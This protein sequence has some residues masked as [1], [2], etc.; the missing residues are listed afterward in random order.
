MKKDITPPPF[1]NRL[2]RWFCSPDLY[3][4]LAGDLAE[5]FFQEEATLDYK[6]AC[7]NYR[8]EV[9][10]M[11]RPSVIKRFT[12]SSLLPDKLMLS[13]YLKI[14]SRSLQ[15]QIGYTLTNIS[16][17]A[18]G[19]TACLLILLY[20]WGES[21]FDKGHEKG[22]RIFRLNT[23]LKLPEQA[24]ALSLTGGPVGP[25]LAH[26]F[27]EIEGVVRLAR[28]WSTLHLKK[29]DKQFYEENVLYADSSFFQLFDFPFIEGNQ[30]SALSLPYSVVISED[31][32]KKYF[33]EGPA[34]GKQL[35]INNQSFTVT[36]I[37]KDLPNHTHVKAD[38]YLSFSS[39][40]IEYPSTATSW[41]WTSF[42]T[43]LLLKPGVDPTTFGQ[44]IAYY[45]KDHV[46]EAAWNQTAMV[47]HLEP[48]EN[49]YFNSPRLG[50]WHAKGSKGYLLF[51]G[52]AAF[53]ILLMAILN[54]INL[55][56]ARAAIRSK[57]IGIRK[58]IGAQRKQLIQQFLTESG[59]LVFIAYALSF[60]ILTLA[61]PRFNQLIDRQLSIV[62]ILSFKP[63]ALVLV[64][65]LTISL[66]AGFYPAFFLSSFKTNS[67]LLKKVD[68]S[69]KKQSFWQ[70]LSGFQF[71]TS[72][73][74]IICTVIA[75]QQVQFMLH[76]DPGFEPDR[77]VVMAFGNDTT[78]LSHRQY[79][80][81]ELLRIPGI[82]AAAYSSHVPSESPHGVYL[83]VEAG[84]GDAREGETE[85][86]AVDQYFIDLYQLKLIAGKPFSTEVFTDSTA[87]LIVNASTVK[88]LGFSTPEEIIGKEFYQWDRRGRVI[89][90]V[91]DFNFKSLHNKIGA[92]T[93][94]LR[95]PLF[96]K[97]TIQYAPNRSTADIIEQLS[98]KWQSLAGHLPFQYSFLDQRIAQLYQTDKRFATLSLLFS[99]LA[100]FIALLGL[101]ALVGY[102]C[103]RQAKDIAV[104]KVFGATAFQ[105]I[106]SLFR[107][108]SRP[109][110]WA[111]L[112][113][114]VPVYFLLDQ[115]LNDFTYRIDISWLVLIGVGILGFLCSFL[116]VFGQSFATAN[117][118]PT[119]YLR[120]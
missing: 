104:K 40:I 35:N 53:F 83:S 73:S 56:T 89:G 37:L 103:R 120:E 31:L 65:F 60:L 21:R 85:M 9:L 39:W 45:I 41:T 105:I 114:I 70:Y 95:A 74:L 22:E 26:D 71:A 50:E 63:I 112:L 67:E 29:D 11:I 42:P 36:G 18:I 84:E 88:L 49:I 92:I 99:I 98:N 17:L 8:R 58:T 3:E 2:F 47:L 54:F 12:I 69:F 51:L 5:Q 116:V 90:V 7:A 30:S 81:E 97:L 86:C 16:G 106:W 119:R 57:E 100:I 43:Y 110:L 82:E 25:A 61:L 66:L 10:L 94:Q 20:I 91:A 15:R 6:K 118:N 28:P 87:P 59:L 46:S 68:S 1:Y 27:P 38:C 44:K 76:R 62:T 75:W 34:Y 19:L 78:I 109:V 52:I 13:N 80:R 111:W 4:E 48:F 32:A 72:I 77:K 64:S 96:E 115:W 23:D 55:S 102:S 33:G 107:Q 24:L 113:V 108:Y 79:I 93:F 101:V 117:A 14:A